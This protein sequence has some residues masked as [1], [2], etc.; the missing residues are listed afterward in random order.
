MDSDSETL[1]YIRITWS[2]VKMQISGLH[3]HIFPFIGSR[4]LLEKFAL[5]RSLPGD[6][7]AAYL[8]PHFEV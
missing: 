7:D 1:E 2:V 5:L 4:V 6:A 3:S 8:G